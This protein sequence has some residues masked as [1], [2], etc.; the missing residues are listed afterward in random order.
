MIGWAGYFAARI[1]ATA[2]GSVADWAAG[3][4]DERNTAMNA[5][6]P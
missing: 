5:A 3:A 1:R 4:G 6:K 2:S